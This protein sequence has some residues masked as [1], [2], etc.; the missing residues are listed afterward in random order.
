[1]LKNYNFNYGLLYIDSDY[2]LFIIIDI[3]LKVWWIVFNKMMMYLIKWFVWVK[4]VIIISGI[5][6]FVLN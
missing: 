1:M 3:L 6:I 2:V 5:L 4:L